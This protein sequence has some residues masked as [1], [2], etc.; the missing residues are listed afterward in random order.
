MATT[1]ASRAFAHRMGI[2]TKCPDRW[3]EVLGLTELR[4]MLR[5]PEE[6]TLWEL[7]AIHAELG[8]RGL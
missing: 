1:R 6:H 5:R 8:R 4:E 3:R 7:A 2:R